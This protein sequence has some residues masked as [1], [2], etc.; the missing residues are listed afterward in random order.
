MSPHWCKR[1]RIRTNSSERTPPT[2]PCIGYVTILT[3]ED[4]RCKS[5]VIAAPVRAKREPERR[6]TRAHPDPRIENPVRREP[7]ETGCLRSDIRMLRKLR[8]AASRNSLPRNNSFA[9]RLDG[10]RKIAVRWLKSPRAPGYSR[11]APPG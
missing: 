2:E 10:A 6:Q 1:Q 8:A 9:R 4:R 11:P 7:P 5:A 3:R